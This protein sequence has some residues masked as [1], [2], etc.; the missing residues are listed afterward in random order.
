M[1]PRRY[2]AFCVVQS[3]HER[4][5]DPGRCSPIR[6]LFQ[7]EHTEHRHTPWRLQDHQDY[8]HLSRDDA[9]VGDELMQG[10]RASTYRP[11]RRKAWDVSA[12]A[13]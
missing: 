1:K 8:T 12:D 4:A 10:R 9:G 2:P 7:Q 13:P 3:S 6:G 5:H 11:R